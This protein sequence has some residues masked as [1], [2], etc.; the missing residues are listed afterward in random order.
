MARGKGAALFPESTMAIKSATL[1]PG[2]MH[3]RHLTKMHNSSL[4]TKTLM[5]NVAFA[6]SSMGRRS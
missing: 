5:N 4:D 3:D 6:A 2:V 1:D